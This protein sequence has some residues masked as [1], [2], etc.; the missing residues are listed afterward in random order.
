MQYRILPLIYLKSRLDAMNL[1]DGTWNVALFS[2]DLGEAGNATVM[3][4]GNI[5]IANTSPPS[6]MVSVSQNLN[7]RSGP[8][9]S[10]DVVGVL[11]PGS[12]GIA[13]GRNE[14]GDW[15]RVQLSDGTLGWT[16]APYV[17]AEGDI[18]ALDVASPDD[19]TP[20]LGPMQTFTFQASNEDQ[21]C[22]QGSGILIQIPEDAG[23]AQFN[24]N[25]V[26][27][28]VS[29]TAHINPPV[30]NEMVMQSL[31]GTVTVSG[32]EKF[33]FAMAGTQLRIPLNVDNMV[34]E[35]PA[36]PQPYEDLSDLPV[37]GLPQDVTIPPPLSDTEIEEA[38]AQYTI[39]PGKW[40]MTH[41]PFYNTCT[42]YEPTELYMR[43]EVG[44][45]EN[46]DSIT[47]DIIDD[48]IGPKVTAI[49][50]RTGLDTYGTGRSVHRVYSPEHM[51]METYNTVT[52]QLSP[53]E[54]CETRYKYVITLLEPAE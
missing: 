24:I 11:Q 47:M 46:G 6:T 42:H 29:G 27:S 50:P 48:Y 19:T 8:S 52:Y 12:N 23:Q 35:M 20:Y 22:S 18:M 13:F 32:G 51:E 10:A 40:L 49:L 28:N 25:G 17:S 36:T 38:L 16:Y 5:Q 44:L 26:T 21:A 14:A 34:A 31:E 37:A 3:A 43:I 54:S 53:T 33:F 15:I 45:L 7:V 30:D 39:I 41:I 1:D 2:I 9:T 4:Y